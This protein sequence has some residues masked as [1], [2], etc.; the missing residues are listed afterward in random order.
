MRKLQPSKRIAIKRVAVFLLALGITIGGIGAEELSAHATIPPEGLFP[1]SQEGYASSYMR[2]SDAPGV[3]KVEG[4]VL[5]NPESSGAALGVT[6]GGVQEEGDD[7]YFK[8]ASAEEFLS[9]LTVVKSSAVPSVIELTA[10]INLGCN[11]VEDFTKYKSVVKAY[12]AQP[13][14]H[15]TLLKTGTSVLKI[16]DISNL[17]IF[18]SNG[19]AIKHANITMNNVDNI[20]IRNIKFDELWEWDEETQGEYDRNDWDY[21]TLDKNCDGVWIDHCTFYKAYDGIVDVKNPAPETNVT[22][23]WCEFL[24]GS[25]DNV[26]FDEMMEELRANPDKYPTYKALQEKGMT[27][28]QI[29]MYCYG[30]KKT[31]LFGHS[32]NSTAA[33]GIRA[34]LANNYYKN[35]M[36]RMPRLRYGYSHVY[37]CVMDSQELLDAKNSIADSSLASEIVSNGASSTCEGYVLLENCYISGITKALNSG[38]GKSPSGYINAVNS[39]YYIDGQAAELS[40]KCNTSGDTRVL[41]TD[42][43]EF[44][45]QLPYEDYRLYAAE[46]LYSTVV[47][48][49]GAGKL[50]YAGIFWMMTDYEGVAAEDLEVVAEG[51]EIADSGDTVVIGGLVI[52]AA[53]VVVVVALLAILI[54]F[55]FRKLKNL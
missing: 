1:F 17:T 11:E 46:S 7:T 5:T 40:P 48:C 3:Y 18:S 16:E 27:E 23:S 32:D 52:V 8:V 37:N 49:A 55:R 33:A 6:G 2:Q 13:L 15:P 12:S 19:S 20:I 22:I 35:S 43:A 47:P 24:P 51:L 34:T 44:V 50:D 39:A 21:M 26:F 14:T 53:V 28:E 38:N 25:E 4:E 54:I 41:I 29:Y 9:A 10:D 31:H 45:S 42:A 36:D 30:Q